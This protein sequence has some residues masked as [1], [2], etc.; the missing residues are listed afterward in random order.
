ME[1]LVMRSL[2]C[3]DRTIAIYFREIGEKIAVV[4]VPGT[5]HGS[6]RPHSDLTLVF[7]SAITAHQGSMLTHLDRWYDNAAILKTATSVNG[8]LLAMSGPRNP[9]QES[10]GV[11]EEGALAH[12]LL[13]HRI[14]ID[15]IELMARPD[16]NFIIMR[17]DKIYKD[18]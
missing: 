2:I 1:R 11:T 13:I 9:K 5:A 12:L 4:R 6:S 17:D 7:S 18:T 8:E 15:H 16:G 10:W 3:E 14:P